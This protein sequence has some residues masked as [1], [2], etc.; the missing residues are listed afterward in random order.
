[1]ARAVGLKAFVVMVEETCYGEKTDHACAAVFFGKRLLLVDPSYFWFGVSHKRFRVLDDLGATA[2]YMSTSV[3]MKKAKIACA[4]APDLPQSQGALFCA[5]IEEGRWN[6]A[7][8]L[9][10]KMKR[11]ASSEWGWYGD[12]ARIAIHERRFDTAADLLTKAIKIN[13]SN[14][15]VRVYLGEAY[16]QMGRLEDARKAFLGSLN[17]ALDGNTIQ[18]VRDRLAWLENAIKPTKG[19]K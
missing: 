3:N 4:L 8:A 5:L 15:A 11:L 9:L 1:L 12:E 7:K 17:C 18:I 13:P 16:L 14:G 10:P 19:V 2:L 6:D